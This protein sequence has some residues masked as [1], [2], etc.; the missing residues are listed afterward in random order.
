MG[1]PIVYGNMYYKSETSILNGDLT[2]ENKLII[3]N[4]ELGEKSG[5]LYDLPM[6]FALFLLKDRNGVITLD[7]PVR[8][9]SKIPLLRLA[10]SYGIPL[11]ISS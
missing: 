1:F 8:G 7:V 6:K 5:G 4:V 11:K 9:D 10:R 3:T 2:S